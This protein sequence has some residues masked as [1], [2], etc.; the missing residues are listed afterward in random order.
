MNAYSGRFAVDFHCH[1]NFS[2]DC[3]MPVLRVLR[4]A[5]RLG[6]HGIAITD[7]DTEEGGLAA[8]ELNPY[9]D[10]LVIPGAEIKTDRGDLIG[11]YLSHPIKSRRFETVLEEIA[12]QGGFTYLPHPLRTFGQSKTL[13][14]FRQYPQMDAWEIQ[15][16]RYRTADAIQSRQLFEQ[17]GV[18]NV[19]AG[20]DSH[21]PWDQGTVFTL[22]QGAPTS[23]AALRQLV[24]SGA[25]G[26]RNHRTEVGLAAGIFAASMTSAIKRRRYGSAVRQV[27]EIPVR[28][29]R[30]A[31]RKITRSADRR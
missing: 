12:A 13:D 8:R 3:A 5:R 4:R 16:G 6:L 20:S 9:P 31:G 2:K 23:A 25:E 11:L 29:A 15:N 21:V 19:L 18:R 14:A 1:T 10:L 26:V 30:F 17:A 27:V 24:A 7:H 22:L 28:A